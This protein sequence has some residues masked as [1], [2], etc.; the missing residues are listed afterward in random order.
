MRKILLPIGAMLLAMLLILPASAAPRVVAADLY[1]R[2]MLVVFETATGAGG[3]S[4]QLPGA[5]DA[6][7]IWCVG[8]DVALHSTSV[9][10]V[11]L[12]RDLPG[13]LGEMEAEIEVKQERIAE[14]DGLMKHARQFFGGSREG[15]EI[16]TDLQ[17]YLDASEEMGRELF[18]LSDQKEKLEARI[19]ALRAY[20]RDHAPA[21]PS[22]AVEV[23]WETAESGH[24]RVYAWSDHA[25]WE[26][27]YHLDLQPEPGTVRIALKG[28]AR[29]RT[30]LDLTG[31]PVTFHT[32]LPGHD[33]RLRSVPPLKVSEKQEAKFLMRNILRKD[34]VGAPAPEQPREPVKAE[35]RE[36]VAGVSF[37]AETVLPGD[38]TEQVVTLE[39]HTAEAKTY[40]ALRPFRQKRGIIVGEIDE[41]PMPLF[42]ATAQLFVDGAPS[43][44]SRIDAHPRGTTAAL[45]FG[46]TD[47]VRAE[48]ID[49]V[50]TKGESFFGTKGLI[51]EA[52]TLKVSNGMPRTVDIRLSDRIPVSTNEKIEVEDVSIGVSPT[53]REEGVLTW[54]RS[55]ASGETFEVEIRYT[56][57]HPEDMEILKS[58]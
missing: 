56:I 38:N 2:G 22:E 55:L 19:Q 15:M 26:P 39:S 48:R 14:I 24:I 44:E 13:K 41:L 3:G 18:L 29:Q 7:R 57:K 28:K 54:R 6:S 21:S 47:Q 51:K 31:R 35:R 34:E 50:G 42:P 43:G 4:M 52:Y 20:L 1:P 12:S 36:S 11:P 46:W 37:T 45:P 17:A 5:F 53:E 32:Q 10:R 58:D 25:R 49:K 40:I 23:A 27:R 30:G 33:V 9:R 8:T 16:R